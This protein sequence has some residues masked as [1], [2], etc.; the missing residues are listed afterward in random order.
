LP[1]YAGLDIIPA[2]MSLLQATND[3]TVAADADQVERFKP[4][5]Q[6]YPLE[7]EKTYDYVIIDNPPD[8]GLNVINALAVSDD[9]IVPTKV[10]AWALEGLDTIIDQVESMK[11]INNKLQFTG[12]LVTMW[13]N[14]DA[15]RAGLEWLH[16]KGY[17]QPG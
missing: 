16:E 15:N 17:L 8:L 11:Q 4:L 13:Q 3:L 9:V 14:D 12:A 7:P 1:G 6:A 5:L 2:N 10:D